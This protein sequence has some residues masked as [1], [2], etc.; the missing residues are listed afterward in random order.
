MYI[1]IWGYKAMSQFLASL[2]MNESNK[3]K[4]KIFSYQ[5]IFFSETSVKVFFC[6]DMK[7]KSWTKCWQSNLTTAKGLIIKCWM[8]G[9]PLFFVHMHS[10]PRMHLGNPGPHYFEDTG[11]P[12][13]PDEA[14]SS[15]STL[16]TCRVPHFM[17][18][19]DLEF[20]KP[21]ESSIVTFDSFQSV[22]EKEQS[23]HFNWSYYCAWITIFH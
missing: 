22:W 2:N 1:K 19:K 10:S 8:E 15:L 12:I 9:G 21:V 5:K 17:T 4:K 13:T 23:R 7:F 16:T 11:Y 18:K 14:A 20:K 3:R 6:E